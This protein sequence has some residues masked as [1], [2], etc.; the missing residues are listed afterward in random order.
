MNAGQ[1]KVPPAKL[2]PY[3]VDAVVRGIAREEEL[4]SGTRDDQQPNVKVAAAFAE[5]WLSP[6]EAARLNTMRFPEWRSDW[7]LGRWTAKNA[8]A[9]DDIK[10]DLLSRAPDL[11]K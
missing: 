10:K 2:R 5:N 3:L 4:H 9:Q 11:L 8:L 7:K 6:S 1:N